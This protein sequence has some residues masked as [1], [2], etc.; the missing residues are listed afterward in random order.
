[1]ILF[2]LMTDEEI[3]QTITVTTLKPQLDIHLIGAPTQTQLK[4]GWQR[5]DYEEGPGVRLTWNEESIDGN[6]KLGIDSGS[7]LLTDKVID[8]TGLK[9]NATYLFRIH[10]RKFYFRFF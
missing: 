2:P 5:Q 3:S 8:V 6:G 4:F 10:E 1:M 9:P 7:V